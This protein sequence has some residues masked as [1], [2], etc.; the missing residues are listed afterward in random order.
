MKK[1]NDIGNR[2]NCIVFYRRRIYGLL[3]FA[4]QNGGGSKGVCV[5]TA[6]TCC[7]MNLLTLSNHSVQVHRWSVDFK[8]FTPQPPPPPHTH[9]CCSNHIELLMFPIQ[10]IVT[11]VHPMTN[12]MSI[13]KPTLHIWNAINEP[14][15]KPKSKSGGK[16]SLS[17][18]TQRREPHNAFHCPGPSFTKSSKETFE[19]HFLDFRATVDSCWIQLTVW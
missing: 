10:R 12:G 18:I 9:T 6:G 8:A 13:L 19:I 15:L 14:P 4:Y 7:R 2:K 3:S 1:Q 5:Q 16:S 17:K 11:P